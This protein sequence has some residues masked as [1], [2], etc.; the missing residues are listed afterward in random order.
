MI[1]SDCKRRR[2][3][4]RRKMACILVLFAILSSMGGAFSVTTHADEGLDPATA[5]HLSELRSRGLYRLAE[6]DIEQR[7]TWSRLPPSVE[8]DLVLELAETMLAHA[9]VLTESERQSLWE[10]AR[11]VVAARTELETNSARRT[12]LELQLVLIDREMALASL[13]RL[14]VAPWNSSSR[15]QG[16]EA[17]SRGFQRLQEISARFDKSPRPKAS[18]GSGQPPL[19]MRVRLRVLQGEFQVWKAEFAFDPSERASLLVT[20]R[21]ALQSLVELRTETDQ[22][23]RA[24]VLLVQTLRLAGETRDALHMIE[25]VRRKMTNPLLLTA[26]TR[27]EIECRLAD[28]DLEEARRL[29]ALSTEPSGAKSEK[30]EMTAPEWEN[31]LLQARVLVSAWRKGS[32]SGSQLASRDLRHAQEVLKRGAEEAP[33][34]W[35]ELFVSLSDTLREEQALGP[36]LAVISLQIDQAISRDDNESAERLLARG[37]ELARQ[38]GMTDRA[39]G[40]GIQRGSRALARKEWLAAADDLLGVSKL[41]S[42]SPRAPEA[43]LLGA[44]ALGRAWRENENNDGRDGYRQALEEFRKR[45]PDDPGR[46]EAEWMLAE[47][48]RWEGQP[49][50]AVEH[51]DQIPR[52]HPRSAQAVEALS[53]LIVQRIRSGKEWED[54]EWSLIRERLQGRLPPPEEPLAAADLSIAL[55]AV[56]LELAGEN[57][58]WPEIDRQLERISAS[59]LVAQ[60]S[61]DTHQGQQEAGGSIALPDRGGEVL[62][63]R[64]RS[65]SGQSR[66]SEI[67]PLLQE[68]MER[69]AKSL[70]P[71]LE[72]MTDPTVVRSGESGALEGRWGVL[73]R[74]ARQ[75]E[76]HRPRLSRNESGRLDW[77]LGRIHAAND[78]LREARDCYERVL[79]DSPGNNRASQ[80]YASFL[81]GQSDLELRRR[82]VEVL[83]RIEQRFRKGTEEWL[84]ARLDLVAGMQANG[85]TTDACRLLSKTRLLY[86]VL[87]TSLQKARI[88]TLAEKCAASGSV[89]K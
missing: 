47:L 82:G 80:E 30:G 17:V 29:A 51:Y 22:A 2:G 86:P 70:L 73:L 27:E 36:E 19:T 61:F 10:R 50:A 20:A 6:A 39:V 44:Y 81:L 33:E 60:E 67:E 7:L 49:A 21:K 52:G 85:E 26:L 69:D 5:V 72:G 79:K 23:D 8:T 59:K 38:R 42:Q 12:L 13:R 18:P 57:P 16:M 34:E 11:E 37:V 14:P 89:N 24:R 88:K 45:F 58:D 1:L 31:L 46:P 76:T 25:V 15:E 4:K 62:K 71:V 40:W 55:A 74:V 68:V 75:L 54:G 3:E 41:F 77:V 63:L 9:R 53:R 78:Q 64:I 83:K 84:E 87:G 56:E 65:L 32:Q 35:R 28:G 66:W 43:Q 48:C